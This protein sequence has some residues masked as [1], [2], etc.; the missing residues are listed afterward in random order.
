MCPAREG[1]AKGRMAMPGPA[2]RHNDCLGSFA[3]KRCKLRV[4]SRFRGRIQRV[5]EHPHPFG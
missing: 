3:V 1:Q 4:D 2:A 5:Y